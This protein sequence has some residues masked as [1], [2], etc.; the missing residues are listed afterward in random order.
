MHVNL[1]SPE[2]QLPHPTA[3][4]APGAWGSWW[5]RGGELRQSHRGGGFLPTSLGAVLLCSQ[6]LASWED[7]GACKDK[8]AASLGKSE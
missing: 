8:R 2:Q 6:E 1:F 4:G 5:G 7:P 3:C